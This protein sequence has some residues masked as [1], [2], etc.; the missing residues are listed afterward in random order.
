MNDHE[1]VFIVLGIFI[2]FFIIRWLLKLLFNLKFKI[3]LIGKLSIV[4]N[5]NFESNYDYVLIKSYANASNNDLIRNKARTLEEAIDKVVKSTAGGEFLKNVKIYELY[6]SNKKV[7]ENYYSVEGDVW[8]LKD[9][10]LHM[11]HG[12]KVGDKVIYK[13]LIGVKKS[14][15]IKNLKN[16]KTCIVKLE[17]KNSV[18]EISYDIINKIN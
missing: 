13:D 8:G 9:K 2:G 7:K 11:Q 18:V 5:R 3:L 15:V 14:G 12:F 6:K 1:F 17:G 10:S 16:E 4:S